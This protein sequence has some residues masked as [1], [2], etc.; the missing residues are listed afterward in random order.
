MKKFTALLGTALF[1]ISTPNAYASA[2]DVYVVKFR[3]D[4]C[5]TCSAMET[6]L[7]SAVAMIGSASVVEVT[8]DSTN[9]LQWEKSAHTAFDHNVVKQF[10]KWIGKTGFAAIVDAKTSRTVGCVSD[11]DSVHKMANFIKSAARLPSDYKASNRSGQFSCP[12]T[13]NVDL[14]K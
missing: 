9:A 6:Q 5:Q 3:A 14:G 1:A 13:F 11:K 8:L 7:S 2:A 10:N 12:A 4:N